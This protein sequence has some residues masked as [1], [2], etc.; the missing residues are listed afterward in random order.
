[1][2]RIKKLDQIVKISQNR[3]KWQNCKVGQ[4]G[5]KMTKLDKNKNQ[6]NWT[7]ETFGQHLKVW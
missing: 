3:Q 4:H 7:K 2:H 6:Q 5:K 1:M